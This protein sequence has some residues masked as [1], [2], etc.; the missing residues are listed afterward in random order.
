ML[1]QRVNKKVFID[2]LLNY[3]KVISRGKPTKSI[4]DL[5]LESYNI[6]KNDVVDEVYYIECEQKEI[7]NLV[8]QF[9]KTFSWDKHLCIC[10]FIGKSTSVDTISTLKQCCIDSD[11]YRSFPSYIVD[12]KIRMYVSYYKENKR[13]DLDVDYIATLFGVNS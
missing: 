6:F 4:Y 10:S 1:V 7:D 13:L 8:K 9:L 5:V 12:N 2:D 11:Y 3:S